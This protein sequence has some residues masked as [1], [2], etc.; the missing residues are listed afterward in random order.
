MIKSIKNS[1]TSSLLGVS[2]VD[3]THYKP[4]LYNLNQNSDLNEFESLLNSKK[5]YL[6]KAN[7]IENQLLELHLTRHPKRQISK[8]DR[9]EWM[10]TWKKNNDIDTYGQWVYYP[11]SGVISH[12]LPENEFIELRTSRNKY[13]ISEAEQKQLS[14]KKLGIIGLSVGQSV[15]L[16]MAIERV[17]GTLRIAD[18]DH[19]D[20]SNLNRIR[21][22]LSN[23]ALPK[24][25]MV[26]R[27]IAEIDPYLKVELYNEGITNDNIDDFIGRGE[28]KLD[29]LIEECDSLDIKILARSVARKQ[30]VPVL[31]DTS[32]RGMLDIERFDLD[33]E[34]PLMHGMIS[35]DSAANLSNLSAKDRLAMV[36]DMVGVDGISPRLKASL[37]EVDESLKTW[38]Q[39]ASS[40]ALGGAITTIAARR[41]LLNQQID[42]GRHYFDIDEVLASTS[43]NK[44]VFTKLEKPSPLKFEECEAIADREGDSYNSQPKL[45][46]KEQIEDIVSQA[47][48]APSGGNVQPWK[49]IYKNGKLSLFHDAH[50]SFSFLD[51]KN[52]GSL[53]GLGAALENVVQRAAFHKLKAEVKVLSQTYSDILIAQV[54]FV[55]IG[56]ESADEFLN[57][58]EQ[59]GIRLT[60]RLKSKVAHAIPKEIKTKIFN[61]LQDTEF[62]VVWLEGEKLKK[63]AQIVGAVERQ[64]ILDPW[65]HDDFIAEARWTKEEAESTRN[66]V[67]L[68]T[69]SLSEAD[70]VGFKLIKDAK[71]IEHLRNWDKGQA[72]VKMSADSL[73]N[74]SALALVY[75]N[76]HGAEKV[77]EGGRIVER[78]WVYLNKMGLAYQPVSPATFMFARLRME[79]TNTS[80]YLM[81]ELKKLR[82]E[83][84][85]LLELPE[86]V[87]DLFLTRIFYADEPAVKSLRKPLESVFKV[88]N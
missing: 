54:Q 41:I 62:N 65:G 78:L 37:L 83:Y 36:M 69:L 26:A 53:I 16:T 45:L 64:R 18:Y 33:P 58:G 50:Y 32:D 84:L 2:D 22:G 47:C 5:N 49:W 42:S 56:F 3:N 67:D 51:F 63:M 24:T 73:E 35:D 43:E 57:L 39:L 70:L 12:I 46:T 14:S 17:F 34:Q 48:W 28:S 8:S 44:T 76:N 71:A 4:I 60:N 75:T 15:A 19:L 7:A 52:R 25:I 6:K 20:L 66:G 88:F 38:P 72:L 23:L 30:R 10:K 87:N 68:R 40:V 59:L 9:A 74:S 82:S 11:W 29:L 85:E 13:K 86:T 81:S 27:E 31:M 80:P 79:D 1:L 77:I 21:S 61:H 55:K